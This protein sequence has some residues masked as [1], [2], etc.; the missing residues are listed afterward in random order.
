MYETISFI[1]LIKNITMDDNLKSKGKF[2]HFK[3]EELLTKGL[4]EFY[5]KPVKEVDFEILRDKVKNILEKEGFIFYSDSLKYKHRE[6]KGNLIEFAI[7]FHH[8]K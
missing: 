7:Q 8:I 2:C 1:Y 4:E 3:K 6:H 5:Y